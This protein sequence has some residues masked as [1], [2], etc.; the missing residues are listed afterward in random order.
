MKLL[1]VL[2]PPPPLSS[3]LSSGSSVTYLLG[4][5]GD[6]NEAIVVYKEAIQVLGERPGQE[7]IARAMAGSSPPAHSKG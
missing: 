2:A 7:V 6:Q 5:L 1:R 4:S 3:S